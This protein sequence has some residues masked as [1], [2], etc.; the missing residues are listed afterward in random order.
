MQALAE[1]GGVAIS[2]TAYDQVKAKLPVGYASLGEQKVKSIAEPVRVYRVLMDPAAAGKTVAAPRAPALVAALPA[3]A[4]A[5]C[6]HGARRPR[7]GGS[8]G[9]TAGDPAGRRLQRAADAKPSLVVLPFDNLSDDTEQG[10]LADGITE[11]L[12]TE[13]A[14][15][16]GLFVISRNAAFTYKGKAV[17]PAQI[18][19]ELG[20]RYILEGSIR[21]AGDDM[22]I[23][24]QLI[25]AETG[26]HIGRSASTAQWA[27]VFALQDNGH[28]GASLLPLN[29]ELSP[30]QSARR[31]HR[32][33]CRI[34]RLSPWHGAVPT[35]LAQRHCR[36]GSEG[37]DATSQRP[38]RSTQITVRHMAGWRMYISRHP[39]LARK[40]MG[41]LGR[42]ARQDV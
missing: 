27:D 37:G 4:A 20:V 30:S 18:A 17:Q 41:M 22:R 32:Q 34:R 42:G 9:S 1:P 5:I 35:S 7:R 39:A 40:D 19:K 21:R 2:G 12:T 31:R 29:C 33:S 28:S 23:N 16:P 6:R 36:G 11:D 3:A 10:Y 15:I 26:G 38:S 14:R 25:D 13:L 8:R 24:A